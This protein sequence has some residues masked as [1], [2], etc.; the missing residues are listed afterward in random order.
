MNRSQ[1]ARSIGPKDPFEPSL[2]T[3]TG[4]TP[5]V[6]AIGA[7]CGAFFFCFV[8]ILVSLPLLLKI[9]QVAASIFWLIALVLGAI[10]GATFPRVGQFLAYTFVIFMNVTLSFTI[11]RNLQEQ[12]LLFGIFVLVEFAFFMT[13]CVAKKHPA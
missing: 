9:G 1:S 6:R 8:A 3:P 5:V 11:G 2:A 4:P 13:H 12:A 7:S 10:G